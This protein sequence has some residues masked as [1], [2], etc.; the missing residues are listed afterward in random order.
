MPAPHPAAIRGSP[1]G[2][3]RRTPPSAHAVAVGQEVE[4]HPV[5]GVMRP[6][7]GAVEGGALEGNPVAAAIERMEQHALAIRAEEAVEGQ[8]DLVPIVNRHDDIALIVASR[9]PLEVA[10]LA[11]RSAESRRPVRRWR[12][13]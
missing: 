3:F 1:T 13:D 5:F 10:T 12:I 7:A 8:R 9:A 11:V 2:I 4:E 6:R